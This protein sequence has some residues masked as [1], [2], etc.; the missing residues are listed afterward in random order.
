M[1]AKKRANAREAN[2]AVRTRDPNSSLGLRH[3]LDIR[4]ST[5]VIPPTHPAHLPAETL[6][7]LGRRHSA[8]R[9][10]GGSGYRPLT[11]GLDRKIWSPNTFLPAHLT[12][13]RPIPTIAP[14]PMENQP[15]EHRQAPMALA[16]ATRV[17]LIPPVVPKRHH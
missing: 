12:H 14:H 13:Q 9:G 11:H 4:I 16:D 15:L 7:R 10:R 6:G 2:S 3:S 17:R 1:T 5:L 8:R